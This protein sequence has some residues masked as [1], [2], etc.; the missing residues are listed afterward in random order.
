MNV[1]ALIESSRYNVASISRL[2]D[3]DELYVDDTFQRRL[4]WGDK[5]KVKLIETILMGYPIPEIHLHAQEMNA[6]TKVA[7]TSIVDGQQRITCLVQYLTNE[8]ALDRKFLDKE[9]RESD[10]AGKKWSDLSQEQKK[11]IL[12]YYFNCRI[13]DSSVPLSEV[14]KVFLRINETDKSLNPQEFRHAKF[15]GLF[16]TLAEELANLD[17]FTAH[18]VFSKNDMRRMVDV[19]FTTSLLGYLRSGVVSDTA[20][21]INKLYDLYNEVYAERDSDRALITDRLAKIH[22]IFGRSKAVADFFSKPV[23]LYTLFTSMDIIGVAR[24]DEWYS[25]SLQKFVIEYEKGAGSTVIERYRRGSE[26][27]TRSKGSRDLRGDSLV[28]FIK[29]SHPKSFG[30]LI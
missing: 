24:P 5:Q 30:A 29:A 26:Q 18:D 6:D 22:R 25:T 21:N 2:Y 27:R 15:D 1:N 10:Y 7:R 12:D 28:A 4:V 8:W 16:I 20:A 11:T 3:N 14:R 17:F 9:N 13:I 19:E 23:H